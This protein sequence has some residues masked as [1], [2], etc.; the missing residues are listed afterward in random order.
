MQTYQNNK[1]IIF[2]INTEYHLLLAKYIFNIHFPSYQPLF[3]IIKNKNRFK[4]PIIFD[5]TIKLIESPLFFKK[6]FNKII[7]FKSFNEVLLNNYD[8]VLSF[9]DAEFVNNILISEIKQ[10]YNSKIILCQDGLAS[11]VND[12]SYFKLLKKTIKIFYIKYFL[13]FKEIS[14]VLKWGKNK[15]VDEYLLTNPNDLYFKT[16]KEINTLEF[17]QNDLFIKQIEKLFNFDIKKLNIVKTDRYIFFLSQGFLDKESRNLEFN[18][19]KKLKQISIQNN[20]K[21]IIKLHPSDSRN[22]IINLID[23]EKIELIKENIP[24]ELILTLFNNSYIISGYST[25]LLTKTKTNKY[26]W[27]YPILYKKF[28]SKFKVE[29]INIIDNFD[30]L[31]LDLN[32]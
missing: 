32:D 31:Q 21:L 17:E 25:S 30:Q 1:K 6:G 10:R 12:Y 9:Q 3:L 18:L 20:L 8:I 27:V 7:F 16:K 28:K 2:L 22:D 19:I 5:T 24:A 4:S 11:Y 23:D 14:F 26:Y 29:H 15:N 13:N